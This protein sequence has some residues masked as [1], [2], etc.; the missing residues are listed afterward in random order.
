M[1]VEVFK[2]TTDNWC[3]NYKIVG[4]CR[5]SDLVEVSF[6]TLA[7]WGDKTN[8]QWRVCVW[9]NDDLG[10]EKDFFEENEAWVCFLTIIGWD[11]VNYECLTQLGF[12]AA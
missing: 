5:V 7:P 10:L 8:K 1:K 4:D 6:L 12:V 2:K 3:G 9:G 11:T